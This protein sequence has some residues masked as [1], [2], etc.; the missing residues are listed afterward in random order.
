MLRPSTLFRCA[1]LVGTACLVRAIVREARADPGLA[2]L[3][4]PEAQRSR[5]NQPA[6]HRP[7]RKRAGRGVRDPGTSDESVS[8][9]VP[10]R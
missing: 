4:A 5:R 1:V 7:N 6:A 8:A 9:E 10:P 2:L 3:P